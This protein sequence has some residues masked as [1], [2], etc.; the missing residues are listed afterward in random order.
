[1]LDPVARPG[2]LDEPDHPLHRGDGIVAEAEREREVEHRLGVGRSLDRRKERVVDLENE[3]PPDARELADQ[4]V[5]HP[6]PLPVA[7]GVR[8]RLLDRRARRG[9]DVREQS[10]EEIP[11]ASSRRLRSFQAGC[12]LR[13]SRGVPVSSCQPT[14]NPSPFVVVAPCRAWRL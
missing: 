2:F 3:L 9:A 12:V 7:E 10:G 4:A 13:Y 1:V 11:A 8:V 14:P 6:E 5:V